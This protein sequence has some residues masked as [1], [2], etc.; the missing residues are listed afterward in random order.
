MRLIC[1]IVPEKSQENPFEFSYYL[2]SQGIAN[3][4]EESQNQYLI[5]VVDEDQVDTALAQYKEY[6]N[7]PKHPKYSTHFEEVMQQKAREAQKEQPEEDS[8]LGEE[9][10]ELNE[11]SR[12][13][14]RRFLS[15]SPYGVVS[16]LIICSAI[17][18]F[19]WAQVQR[20]AVIPPKIPGV[21]QAPM[22]APLEQK[23]VYDYPSYFSMRDKLLGIYTIKDIEQKIPPSPQATSLI[24]ELRKIPAWMGFYDRFVLYMRNKEFSISYDGPMFE[25]IRQGEV[26]RTFTP[27]LLHFDFLHIFFNILWFIILGNQ[28]EHRLGSFRYLGLILV[29][30]IFSNTGQYLMSGPFFMGLSGI[31][32]GMA[33]FIWARQQIAPWEGYLLHRFTLIFLGIFVIG[34]FFLQLAFF[35]MQIFGSFEVSIGIANTAHLVGAGVGYSMGRLRRLFAIRQSIKN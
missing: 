19:I 25:D 7:N 6:Q 17:F 16:I 11:S 9:Q 24:Q 33:S 23:L 5:W 29:L 35:F 34:M 26:W 18:L 14:R 15:S 3:E 21:I 1:T 27:A 13:P 2:V 22:L 28:I 32:C 20:E 30:G 4:C 10:Q 12:A 8:A 31:V